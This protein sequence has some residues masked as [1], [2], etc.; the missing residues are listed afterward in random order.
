M[1]TYSKKGDLSETKALT[2]QKEGPDVIAKEDRGQNQ[3]AWL[4]ELAMFQWLY[5]M[6]AQPGGPSFE[7]DTATSQ[8][9]GRPPLLISPVNQGLSQEAGV[10][11]KAGGTLNRVAI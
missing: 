9:A 5:T 8:L 2:I 10:V 4:L 11:P 1:K 6:V 7:V 3:K